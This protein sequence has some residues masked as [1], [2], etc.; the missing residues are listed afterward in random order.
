MKMY[1][2]VAV[3]IIMSVSVLGQDYTQC[4]FKTTPEVI[5]LDSC[6]KLLCVGKAECNWDPGPVI[7][8]L[9]C[10]VGLGEQCP[11]VSQCAV[12]YK[13]SFS[14]PTMLDDNHSNTG[15]TNPE[16]GVSR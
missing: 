5:K 3:A 8:S 14:Q 6:N 2:I 9:G 10:T 13:V 1:W 7:I 4:T 11:P 12:D 15:S 16:K